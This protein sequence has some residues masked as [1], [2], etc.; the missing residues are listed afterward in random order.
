MRLHP[1]ALLVTSFLCS[2]VGVIA[3]A[4]AQEFR[5]LEGGKP[6]SKSEKE[7]EIRV[8]LQKPIQLDANEMP[9]SQVAENI[10]SALH[11]NVEL[12][13]R[14]LDVVGI[15]PD[16]P[17]TRKIQNISL[18]SA[19]RIVLSE[20][21]LTY[22]IDDESL[23]ITTFEEADANLI[24]RVYGI[25]DL[26]VPEAGHQPLVYSPSGYP[27]NYSNLIEVIQV[28]VVPDSWDVVGGAGS[29]DA[30]K[31]A[32]VVSQTEKGHDSI[33]ETLEQMRKMD[34]EARKQQAERAEAALK[35]NIVYTK[36][37]PVSGPAAEQLDQLASLLRDVVDFDHVSRKKPTFIRGKAKSIVVRHIQ[38]AHDQVHEVLV[39]LKAIEPRQHP[40][41]NKTETTKCW[42]INID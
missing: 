19:L 17:I 25:R 21:E 9:L 14:A 32:L 12:D 4:S 5:V 7:A 15:S 29:I 24:T 26:V 30:D 33:A 37:Y 8:A 13:V 40:S 1:P 31:F 28:T 16:T 3:G 10:E 34:R 27:S 2:I 11:I 22:R 23:I 41:A 39:G 6:L 38:T 35:D 18:K 42:G 20:L 36:V